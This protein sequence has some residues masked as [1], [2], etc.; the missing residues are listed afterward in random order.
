MI[1]K[2]FNNLFIFRSK[3][4]ILRFPTSNDRYVDNWIIFRTIPRAIDSKY[5][6][7]NVYENTGSSHGGSI[8]NDNQVGDAFWDNIWIR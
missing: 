5:M 3:S 6:V 4:L 1:F 2:T 8:L 7:G